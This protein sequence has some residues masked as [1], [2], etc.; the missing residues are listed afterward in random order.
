MV[1]CVNACYD[2][3]MPPVPKKQS[4][5]LSIPLR[6]AERI[7]HF[8]KLRGLSQDALAEVA[9]ISRKQISDYELD[10]VRPNDEVILRLVLA[11]GVSSDDLLG[12][13]DLKMNDTPNLR[14]TRR[15]RELDQL[16]ENKKKIILKTLDDLIRANS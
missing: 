16:P 5:P 10:R 1:Q 11:L 9:G 12:L 7:Q 15:V 3:Y 6:T 14:F 4:P 2:N 8:R 13:T